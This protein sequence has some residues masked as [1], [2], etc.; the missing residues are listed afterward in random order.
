MIKKYDICGKVGEYTDGQ[1]AVR[2]R[3]KNFGAVLENDKGLFILLD[4]TFN[5]A[6]L[7][8]Q[9]KENILLSLFEPKDSN[10]VNHQQSQQ[11][12]DNLGDEVPF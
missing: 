8:E 4:K 2:A 11:P 5:P 10:Q 3:F 7:A 9:G 6:G 1:G 12:V